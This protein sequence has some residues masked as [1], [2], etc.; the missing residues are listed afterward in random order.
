M[1]KVGNVVDAYEMAKADLNAFP[2]DIWAQ[3]KMGWALYYSL[4]SDIENKDNV[5][6]CLSIICK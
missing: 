1:C 2:Q 3:R 4:K 6:F 5:T